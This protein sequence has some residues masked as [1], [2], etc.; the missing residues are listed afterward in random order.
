MSGPSANLRCCFRA[1]EITSHIRLLLLLLLLG[2][3]TV[4]STGRRPPP[5]PSSSG[6]PGHQGTQEAAK[7][8]TAIH[9]RTPWDTL[10]RQAADARL[11]K[12]IRLGGSRRVRQD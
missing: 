5:L 11:A 2:S 6:R 3:E 10:E 9:A 4:A 1:N 7:Q 8:Q 12:V